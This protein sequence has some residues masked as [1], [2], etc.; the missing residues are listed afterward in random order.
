MDNPFVTT[1][2]PGESL[3]S[4]IESELQG[5]PFKVH[6]S[7]DVCLAHGY[8]Y[9][10]LMPA[11]NLEMNTLFP[12]HLLSVSK[13]FLQQRLVGFSIQLPRGGNLSPIRWGILPPPRQRIRELIELI[14]IAIY[15]LI[16]NGFRDVILRLHRFCWWL[17]PLTLPIEWSDTSSATSIVSFEWPVAPPQ[18]PDL[19]WH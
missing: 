9:F 15:L 19:P 8:L 16:A 13:R 10:H 12:R 6:Y 3:G 14:L 18:F 4:Q 11:A 5:L 17:R 2:D 1:S 7:L